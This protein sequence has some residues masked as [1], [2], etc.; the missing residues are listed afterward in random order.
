MSLE[1][2]RLVLREFVRGDWPA[3][4]AYQSD[5]RYLRYYP[6]EQ[7]TEQEVK[8]FVQRFISWQAQVPRTRFQ[9]AITLAGSGELIGN[10]GIRQCEPRATQAQ[11][12]YELAPWHWGQGYASEAAQAMLGFAFR[13]LAVHR[14]WGECIAENEASRRVME[15]LGLRL[16]GRLREVRW[17]KGCWWDVLI[18]GI[19][20]HEWLAQQGEP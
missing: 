9:L 2:P 4:L 17:M 16:E 3:V 11:L 18:Y 12:G 19:L 6:W 1:T 13:D 20:V 7:R 15:R 14:V 8:A 10:C 5:P